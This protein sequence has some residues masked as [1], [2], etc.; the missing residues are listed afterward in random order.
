M[1]IEEKKAFVAENLQCICDYLRVDIGDD[2]SMVTQS[3]L[4]ALEYIDSAVGSF[5]PDDSTAIL[6]FYALTQ[7]FY[8]NRELMQSE[9][10]VKKR[11]EFT[12]QSIILQLRMKYE[13][14]NGGTA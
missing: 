12:Y 6:L 7:D 8:D 13:S 11:Q 4:A 1:T 5:N 14:K 10:Q 9:Q 3:A 2:D